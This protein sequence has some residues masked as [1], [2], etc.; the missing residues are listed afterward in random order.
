MAPSAR[1][2][3]AHSRGKNCGGDTERQVVYC[4]PSYLLPRGLGPPR[5]RNGAWVTADL[6]MPGNAL[7]YEIPDAAQPGGGPIEQSRS[8]K[9][10][11]F[12]AL[13]LFFARLLSGAFAS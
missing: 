10:R 11:L 4:S 2:R 7:M 3:R 12:P 1:F 13:I 8:G 9:E 5:A 6:S